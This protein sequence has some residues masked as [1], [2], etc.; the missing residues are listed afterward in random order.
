MSDEG[1]KLTREEQIY[2]LGQLADMR[3]RINAA[4]LRA[5]MLIRRRESGL[6]MLNIND[7]ISDVE[8]QIAALR[9]F[10]S[11]VE[12]RANREAKVAAEN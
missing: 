4:N 1:F 5:K 3:E 8:M 7:W 10:V 11:T 9:K 6:E 2:L 12:R